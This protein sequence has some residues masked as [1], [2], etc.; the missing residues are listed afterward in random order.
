MV[1]CLKKS[2]HEFG[3]L[4]D[5]LK[6]EGYTDHLIQMVIGKGV[7]PY[8]Y[9][10]SDSVLKET[11]LPPI[12]K[13]YSSLKGCHITNDEYELAQRVFKEGKC[14][15]M[16]DY[17]ELY[18]KTDVLLLAEIFQN[19][20]KTIYSNHGLDPACLLTISSL[21]VQAAMMQTNHEIDLM[22]DISMLTEFECGIRGGL[23]SV[24]QGRV[25]FNNKYLSSFDENKPISTGIFLDVNGLYAYVLNG[26]LPIGEIKEYSE[27]EVKKFN[28]EES[29]FD[30]N[31][32]FALLI[33]FE[34]PDHVKIQ[35]DDL[36]LS[37]DHENISFE[38]VSPFTKRLIDISGCNFT[39]QKTLVASHKSREKYLISLDLLKLYLELGVICKKIHKVF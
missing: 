15:T 27:E 22:R 7:F 13:F 19:F 2:N 14:K 10:D 32:C 8:E 30:E 16:K 36:P 35:T 24:V 37:I 33:D 4:K 31:H 17:L 34:I 12:D 26:K 3:I 9:L 39:R 38:D 21:A 1:E 25:E 23:T 6:K 5:E 20:R 18:L 11:T 29:Y 28:I